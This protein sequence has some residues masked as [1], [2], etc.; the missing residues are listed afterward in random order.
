MASMFSTVFTYGERYG[1]NLD[2]TKL[3]VIYKVI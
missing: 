2:L 1:E 3:Y